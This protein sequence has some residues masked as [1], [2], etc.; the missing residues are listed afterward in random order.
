MEMEM[1]MERW[2]GE[3]GSPSPPLALAL[4]HKQHRGGRGTG[5]RKREMFEEAWRG[6]LMT[7]W[8]EIEKERGRAKGTCKHKNGS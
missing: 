4:L 7:R 5:G 8:M 2:E 3:E 6:K 1:E